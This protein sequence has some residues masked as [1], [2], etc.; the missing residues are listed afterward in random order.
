[1]L[2]ITLVI[3]LLTILL[4]A[5]HIGLKALALLGILP[6]GD[7]TPEDQ[8]LPV[9]APTQA[10]EEQLEKKT[11]QGAELSEAGNVNDDSLLHRITG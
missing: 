2:K 6:D 3:K 10:S 1:M 11:V 9:T 5:S 4:F 8:A 7:S